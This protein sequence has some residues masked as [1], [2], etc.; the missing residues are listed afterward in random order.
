MLKKLFK[1]KYLLICLFAY[2]LIAPSAS[3]HVLQTDGTIGTVLHIDP[4]DDPIAQQQASLFFEFKD[5]TNN[6]TAKNCDCNVAIVE[7]GKTIYAQPLSITSDTASLFYTFPNPDVYQVVITG[8]PLTKNA[9]QTFKLTYNVRAEQPTESATNNQSPNFL[10]R[11]LGYFIGGAIIVLLLII[12]SI[13][14]YKD[15]K[16]IFPK[17]QK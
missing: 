15:H 2:L 9:F 8:T 7:A 11:Y 13:R 4:N 17:P 5:T 1:L 3:A 6:F 10:T 16:S 14:N 12:M